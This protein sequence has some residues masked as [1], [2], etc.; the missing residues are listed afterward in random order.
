MDEHRIVIKDYEFFILSTKEDGEKNSQIA[1]KF[2]QF[3]DE[4]SLSE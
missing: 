1:K 4:R 2:I 3:V